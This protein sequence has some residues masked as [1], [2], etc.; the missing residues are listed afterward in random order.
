MQIYGSEQIVSSLIAKKTE[1]GAS[2]K[3][4]DLPDDPDA[5]LYYVLPLAAFHHKLCECSS[6]LFGKAL[7]RGCCRP[8]QHQRRS[9]GR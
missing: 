7:S 2:R 9:C 6:Q 1:S 3:N 4:P 8:L 5:T